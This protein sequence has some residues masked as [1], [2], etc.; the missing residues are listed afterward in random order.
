MCTAGLSRKELRGPRL[1]NMCG[2]PRVE[3]EGHHPGPAPVAGWEL[4]T[5]RPWPV[6]VQCPVQTGPLAAL[7]LCHYARQCQGCLKTLPIVRIGDG[8][9]IPREHGDMGYCPAM[10][11]TAILN[12]I[13]V[14]IWRRKEDNMDGRP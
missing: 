11:C 8:T 7:L 10:G 5:A 2:S 3:G 4:C 14:L 9:N 6:H 1:Q 13:R 12:S